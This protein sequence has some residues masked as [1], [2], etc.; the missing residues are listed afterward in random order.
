MICRVHC[1]H[2]GCLI[3]ILETWLARDW[4]C[5]QQA[6][7][8]PKRFQRHSWKVRSRGLPDESARFD[9]PSA[10]HLF[11]SSRIPLYLRIVDKHSPL[12]GN[13]WSRPHRSVS[14]CQRLFLG[15]T[16]MGCLHCF[17]HVSGFLQCRFLQF[18]ATRK[19]CCVQYFP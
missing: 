6:C 8:L 13:R 9:L 17:P 4:I 18:A 11:H 2:M 19:R 1:S 15:C 16:P 5:I 12:A 7:H 3:C 14:C 10:A